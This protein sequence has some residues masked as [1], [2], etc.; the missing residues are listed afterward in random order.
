MRHESMGASDLARDIAP[1]ARGPFG[2][3]STSHLNTI[4]VLTHRTIMAIVYVRLRR[5]STYS[6]RDVQ[7]INPA[8]QPP[9]PVVER[10]TSA[11]PRRGDRPPRRNTTPPR[12]HRCE[13]TIKSKTACSTFESVK[14]GAYKTCGTRRGRKALPGRRRRQRLKPPRPGSSCQVASNQDWSAPGVN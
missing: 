3:N 2:C 7:W 11:S 4:T 13:Q 1:H 8:L 9:N 5:F 12:A 10:G 6:H 14:S